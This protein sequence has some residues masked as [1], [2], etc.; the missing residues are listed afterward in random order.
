MLM[1]RQRLRNVAVLGVVVAVVVAAV[2]FVGSRGSRSVSGYCAYLPDAIGLYEG[3]PVTRMGYELGK[4][5][6][7]SAAG[8]GVRVGFSVEEGRTIP[9]GAAAVTR[10]KS[11][12]A[13]RSL[14]LVGNSTGHALEPGECI[15]RENSHTPKSISE[16]MGSAAD[17]VE[18]MAPGGDDRTIADSVD[19][20][21]RAMDG[22]G[23]DLDK[24]LRTASS[25]VKNPDR[26]ISDIGA[27]IVATGPLT[28]A[29][30]DQW[31]DIASIF[32]K[33]PASMRIGADEMWPGLYHMM[34]GLSPVL[35]MV[36]DVMGRYGEDI[37]RLLDFAGTAE[38]PMAKVNSVSQ[39]L[40]VLPTLASAATLTVVKGK[41]AAVRVS[42]PAVTV[43]HQRP[44]ILCQQLNGI[45]TGSCQVLRDGPEPAAKVNV[46]GLLGEVRR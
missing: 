21:A 7:I 35:Q 30:L 33:L 29:V 37:Y 8:T 42:G 23:A 36:Y 3:N 41:G 9:A 22:G 10:S 17:L 6:S 40:T 43:K 27:I 39:A 24:L 38:I 5:T 44:E 16:I 25:A 13:D 15:S 2:A 34:W 19:A 4:I 46:M 18:E 11:V 32:R 31:R 20:I 12:L 26:M 28:G 1:S 14:E 45:R